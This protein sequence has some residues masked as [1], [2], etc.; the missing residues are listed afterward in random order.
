[1]KKIYKNLHIIKMIIN[2]V[3]SIRIAEYIRKLA[4]LLYNLDKAKSPS[5]LYIK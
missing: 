2:L 5:S 4:K 3:L 1:M